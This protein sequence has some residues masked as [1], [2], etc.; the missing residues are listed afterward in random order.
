QSLTPLAGPN[1]S[2]LK[3]LDALPELSR[4]QAP[5]TPRP[6]PGAIVSGGQ[7]PMSTDLLAQ[8]AVALASGRIKVVDLTQTLQA[9][10]PV[11]Q[12][13]PP[14]APSDPFS[15]TVISKYDEKGPAWY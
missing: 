13:P 12:L 11:I 7:F 8:F 15:A 1:S 14:F 9:S 2:S 6:A 3:F 5:A 10:T 4:L